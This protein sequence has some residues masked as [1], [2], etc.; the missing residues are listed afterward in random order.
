SWDI[1]GSRIRPSASEMT[2]YSAG[3][4]IILARGEVVPYLP[5]NW[6]RSG[7]RNRPRSTTGCSGTS[8]R[9]DRFILVRVSLRG[10][11]RGLG[12]AETTS[13]QSVRGDCRSE[14]IGTSQSTGRWAQRAPE[15][16]WRTR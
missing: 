13:D 16:E 15:R 8:S 7:A 5:V 11:H 4:R 12:A 9:E 1:P 3:R 6:T 2:F 14:Q 10:G